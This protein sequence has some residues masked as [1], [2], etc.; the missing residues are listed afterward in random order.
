MSIQT[1][2]YCSLNYLNQWLSKDKG[3]CE[4]LAG[5]DEDK[6][7]SELKKAATFYKIARN[8]HGNSGESI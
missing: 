3:Y 1:F 2:E 7:L 5:N 6:K 4:T 8:L